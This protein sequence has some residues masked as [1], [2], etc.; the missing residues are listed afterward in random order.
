VALSHKL[1]WLE[2]EFGQASPLAF[3]YP[4]LTSM[5]PAAAAKPAAA[6][7]LTSRRAIVELIART[8]WSVQER[9]V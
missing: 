2:S 8:D 6:N 9:A 3:A 1:V 7:P 5:L 4:G